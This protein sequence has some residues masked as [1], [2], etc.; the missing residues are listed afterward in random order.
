MY[1]AGTYLAFTFGATTMLAIAYFLYRLMLNGFVEPYS[2][3]A[4]ALTGFL[5]TIAVYG[6]SPTPHYYAALAGAAIAVVSAMLASFYIRKPGMF[7]GLIVVLIA[8]AAA[9]YVL[10]HD[11]VPVI[12]MF[13]IG[14]TYGFVPRDRNAGNHKVSGKSLKARNNIEV[15]RDVVQMLFGVVVA[16]SVIALGMPVG[17]YAIFGMM[18]FGY[19]MNDML[20]YDKLH[21]AYMRILKL[22]RESTVFGLGAVYLAIGT[23]FLV[24]FVHNESF[25]LF[26][27]VALFFADSMATILGVHIHGPTLPYNRDKSVY[28]T[29]GFFVTLAIAGYFLIGI[30]ALPFA[31][32]MAISESLPLGIDDNVQMGITLVA[33]Y[34]ALGAL[35]AII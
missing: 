4:S 23:A 26:G 13:A 14:T 5:A 16:L 8:M 20:M 24:G 27:I 18:L 21:S 10:L 35:T 6:W 31:M 28:G 34:A 2:I 15:N 22:E 3:A 9:Y 33:L 17:A 25:V 19:L 11:F 30:Y 29:L 32:L 1:G 12:A 7:A